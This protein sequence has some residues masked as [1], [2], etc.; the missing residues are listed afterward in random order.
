MADVE[1]L[2][3]EARGLL[4]WYAR[5]LASP[6]I[7]WQAEDLFQEGVAAFLRK[8][9][10]VPQPHV[11]YGIVEARSRMHACLRDTMMQAHRLAGYR[12]A[13]SAPQPD[14]LLE[15]QQL[16]RQLT[17]ALAT[18]PARQARVLALY[19]EEEMTVQAIGA[20]IGLD[21][22]GVSRDLQKATQAVQRALGLPG[23]ARKAARS[24]CPGGHPWTPAT[25][26]LF[27]T[28]RGY[29]QR[30]CTICRN[31]AKKRRYQ[32]RKETL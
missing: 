27:T 2:L 12:P 24:R 3:Q 7:G 6:A 32:K 30:G 17:E 5:R 23:T 15:Q 1:A 26:H 19:Y 4:W 16:W 22:S 18:L 20:T 9:A 28:K 21:H 11:A 31:Q 10:G 8:L 14:A 29:V 13:N 25:T